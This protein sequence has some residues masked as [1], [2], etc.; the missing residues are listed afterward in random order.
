[1]GKIEVRKRTERSMFPFPLETC[2]SHQHPASYV[3]VR[4]TEVTRETIRTH[5]QHISAMGDLNVMV[6]V[7]CCPITTACGPS[8]PVWC[9]RVK[10][11]RPICDTFRPKL[12]WSIHRR[13]QMGQGKQLLKFKFAFYLAAAETKSSHSRDSSHSTTPPLLPAAALS[14]KLAQHWQTSTGHPACC[15][16]KMRQLWVTDRGHRELLH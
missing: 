2:M 10:R 16:I 4:R 11:F 6:K 14:M 7:T 3:G 9:Q 13:G 1:M 15:I 8:R 5:V 12:V